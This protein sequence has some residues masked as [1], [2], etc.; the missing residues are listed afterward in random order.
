MN[1]KQILK[2]SLRKMGIYKMRV[3]VI[4][5]P[6]LVLTAISVVVSS[7]LFSIRTVIRDKVLEKMAAEQQVI[8]VTAF[9]EELPDEYKSKAEQIDG[10]KLVG[11]EYDLPVQQVAVDSVDGHIIKPYIVHTL[12][13]KVGDVFS[14]EPFEYS[15]AN[16]VPIIL[17]R[18]ALVYQE[19]DWGGKDEILVSFD[20][21]GSINDLK[22]Q[23]P[24]KSVSI[25]KP[26]KDLVNKEVEVSFGGLYTNPSYTVIDTD[27]GST[28]KKLSSE[29]LQHEQ[30]AREE[31]ISKYWDY[32]KLTNPITFKAKI[33]AI[34]EDLMESAMFVPQDFA[35]IVL[36]KI[37]TRENEARKS[38]INGVY[39]ASDFIGSATLDEGLKPTPLAVTNEQ[40]F[41]LGEVSLFIAIGDDSSSTGK[42]FIPGLILDDAGHAVADERISL[43]D[44]SPLRMDV[45]IS[46]V[47]NRRQVS[48]D[49]SKALGDNVSVGAFSA[50]SSITMFTD[51]VNKLMDSL[52][53]IFVIVTIISVV[54]VMS[55]IVAEGERE[56]G[57][58]RALGATKMAI[59]F[60]IV[61]QT[62][63][64]FL[65]ALIIGDMLGA[66]SVFAL[67]SKIAHQANALI[68]RGLDYVLPISVHFETV[69][70]L[71]FDI[72][73]VLQQHLLLIVVVALVALIPAYRASKI[74]PVDAM[75]RE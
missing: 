15:D 3:A 27:K 35:D 4:I 28:Y 65:I 16:P 25:R 55:K 46:D 61:G 56:I 36:N 72:A 53:I 51:F 67:S 63:I 8:S 42:I 57:I 1:P 62:L 33:V 43:D 73:T 13:K 7:E 29:Q 20:S 14:N 32:Q 31:S 52:T 41:S 71:H 30:K 66:L 23:V 11:F 9:D 54:G 64:Y 44:L 50:I 74:T 24:V 37:T 45:V 75:R 68:E 39:L 22:D 58:F 69:D 6:V 12:T 18:K 38:T 60:L 17:S 49:L 19:E 70:F 5:V 34:R 26:S 48:N 21:L 10:V 47:K 40:V 59:R 2:V